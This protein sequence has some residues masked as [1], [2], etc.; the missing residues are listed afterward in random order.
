MQVNIKTM[1]EKGAEGVSLVTM[2]R[3]SLGPVGSGVIS[4]AYLFLHYAL[5]VACELR[6]HTSCMSSCIRSRRCGSGAA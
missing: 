6:A 3:R 1:R 4:A 2:A 5:L